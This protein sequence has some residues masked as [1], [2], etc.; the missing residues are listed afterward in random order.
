MRKGYKY[1]IYPTK[2]Q[3]TL[4]EQTLALCCE[5]YN[6]A[7]QERKDAY[8]TRGISITYNNQQ[9]QLPDIK[10]DRPEFA[11]VH[12]QVLQDALK[13]LDK[14]MQAFFR[15]CKAGQ[16][17]GFPR[18]RSRKR[19]D[20]FTYPQ[21]GYDIKDNKLFLSK[22]GHVKIKLHRKMEGTIKTCTMRRSPTGKWFACFSCEIEPTALPASTEATGI[23]A[24]LACFATLSNG[25][26]IDSPRFL[27]KEEDALAKVQRKLAKLPKGSKERKKQT[28]VVARVHERITNKRQDF[29]HQESSKLVK[30]FGI[31]CIE[32]LKVLNMMQNRHLAKSIADAA[33]SIFFHCLTYKAAYAGR[34]VVKVKPH[35]TSQICHKCG[36]RK[37]DL[38][39]SHRVYRCDNT[40]CKL[41]MDRDLNASINIL[42]LGLQSVGSQSIEAASL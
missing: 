13:R 42:A 14:A 27:R 34:V 10:K 7:L 38:T 22:L 12:S 19:Y 9:N 33:W 28:R 32:D 21:G 37:K 8:K 29:I 16:T 17:P 41:E 4:L 31:I 24:G 20:S 25:A 39:L 36:H 3:E 6:G 5:L 15:R 40:E 18:F 35:C 23:D 11:Q 26:Q 1:R 30:K 2:K